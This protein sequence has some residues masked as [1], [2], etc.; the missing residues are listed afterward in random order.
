MHKVV[1]DVE[2]NHKGSK[3]RQVCLVSDFA[4]CINPGCQYIDVPI[5][6]DIIEI[7]DEIDIK[8]AFLQI[9]FH[10]FVIQ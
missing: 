5:S 7:N 9:Q 3:L 4:Y 6:I 8:L 2:L 10:D 1:E